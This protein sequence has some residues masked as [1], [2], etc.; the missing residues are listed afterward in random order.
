M[1]RGQTGG[2]GGGGLTHCHS[3]VW[4][5][6][7]LQNLMPPSAAVRRAAGCHPSRSSVMEVT[8][9]NDLTHFI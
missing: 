6:G 7:C 5:N 8:K 2:G 9:Y 1:G 3:P 4:G